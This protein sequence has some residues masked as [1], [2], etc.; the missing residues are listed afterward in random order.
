M[1]TLF[2][3]L[4]PIYLNAQS[5]TL[6]PYRIGYKWGF[7]DT[8]GNIKIKPKYKSALPFYFGMAR[9]QKGKKYGFIN[10]EGKKI[11]KIKY[12]TATSFCYLYQY[13]AK[14]RKGK[15]TFTI[16]SKG[17]KEELNEMWGQGSDI[18]RIKGCAFTKYL[19]EF[20]KHPIIYTKSDT[21]WLSLDDI[22]WENEFECVAPVKAHGKW[23]A[24]NNNSHL[25]IPFE[26][27]EVIIQKDHLIRFKKNNL[28]GLYTAKGELLI[29]NIYKSM[30]EFD[31]GISYI[32]TVDGKRGYI[33]IKNK[34]YFREK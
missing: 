19:K 20:P 7:A 1:R 13:K 2:L 29:S 18:I 4:L 14:V 9:V 3:I 5:T 6:I 15:A 12:D 31:N 26:N 11:I 22:I 27:E 21:T 25:I 23:G 16:N 33:D 28:W 34:E 30:S 24:V 10:T 32:E 8:S 17:E